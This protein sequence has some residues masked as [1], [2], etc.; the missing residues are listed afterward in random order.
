MT[1]VALHLGNWGLRVWGFAYKNTDPN[2]ITHLEA[3][4][5]YF[6]LFFFQRAPYLSFLFF[7]FFLLSLKNIS[8]WVRKKKHRP[9]RLEKGV[10]R[11]LGAHIV[12]KRTWIQH[13]TRCQ[14]WIDSLKCARPTSHSGEDNFFFPGHMDC[15]RRQLRERE[16]KKRKK[17]NKVKVQYFLLY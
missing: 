15:I 9:S 1:L 8:S 3:I 5:M 2:Q 16:R 7:L 14:G 6:I 12:Q 11:A 10:A 4:R 17:E 13:P